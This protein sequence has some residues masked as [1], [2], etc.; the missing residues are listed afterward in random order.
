MSERPLK[1]AFVAV[2]PKHSSYGLFSIAPLGPVYLATILKGKGYDVSVYDEARTKVFNEKR[3]RVHPDLSA[4]DV[5]GLS[6]ISP[7]AK[8]ALRMVRALREQY[9]HIRI[10][11]GGPHVLGP[12]QAEAFAVYADAVVQKEGE[13]VIE[14]VVN[15]EL[16]GII[17]GKRVHDLDQLPV[18]DLNLLVQSKSKLLDFFKL[19]PIST[20]RGCPRNCEFC[21]V[22]N[23]HGKKV[24]RRSPERVMQEIRQRL[25]E[26]YKQ[27]FF[28]D[29]NFSVQPSRRQ[30]LLEAMIAERAKGPWFDSMIIQDEVPGILRGGPEYVKLLKKA[31]IKTIMLGV[32]SFDDEKLKAMH[33][34]HSETDS[35][36]AIRLIRE[37]GLL[38]YAFGMAKPEIDD[39][40]SIRRQFRKLREEGVTYADMTIETPIPGTEYWEQY[41]DKLTAMENGSPDW[42]KWTFLS[43]VIPTKHLSQ[44]AFQKEV[45]R[46]MQRFYSPWRALKDIFSGRLRRGLTI[47]YVWFTTGRMYV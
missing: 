16:N 12:E 45:K 46:S 3:E 34:N 15:G 8:R 22:S 7:A 28:V 1:I 33:K 40:Q 17:Q 19:T 6:V 10:M 29:D 2:R 26:G 27:I 42:D 9:P 11:V 30:Q 24:R 21:T 31:G 44:K 32:E 37:Q 23:I 4:Y 14:E 43:P 39:R 47:L 25:S 36:E 35:E 41:K 13:P 18:P 20:T 38:I 5:I